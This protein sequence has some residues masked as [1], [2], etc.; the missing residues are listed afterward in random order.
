MI[1]HYVVELGNEEQEL[2][3]YFTNFDEMATFVNDYVNKY[4]FVGTIN[5]RVVWGYYYENTR[6]DK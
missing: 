3:K 2:N 5:I 6:I 1:K 4:D